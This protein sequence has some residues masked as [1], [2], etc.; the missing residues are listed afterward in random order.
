MRKWTY[1]VAALL[2]SGT[3]AT[4]TGCIDNDEPA[5]ITELRGAKAE[6]LRAKAAVQNAEAAFRTANAAYRQAEAD[7][8]A[9]KAK[10]EALKTEWQ[11]AQNQYKKDT[12][13]LRAQL[14]AETLTEMLFAQQEQ[15]KKAEQAYNEAMVDLE[16]SMIMFKN[17]KYADELAKV[18]N[19]YT[20]PAASGTGP[21]T[22]V[23]GLKDIASSMA[24]AQNELA[25]LSR[26]KLIIQS[27]FNADDL[28]NA[29][30][31]Q[32][33]TQQGEIKG[34]QENLAKLKDIQG[35]P[36][37][38]WDAK[39]QELKKESEDITT[40]K[41]ALATAKASDP[42]YMKAKQAVEKADQ[43]LKVESAFTFDVPAS[44][45]DGFHSALATVVTAGGSSTGLASLTAI[46]NLAVQ[47][48]DFKYSYPNGIRLSARVGADSNDAGVQHYG[49]AD[50]LVG[51]LGAIEDKVLTDNELIAAKAELTAAQ[52]NVNVAYAAYK[53]D[54]TAWE[55]A[56]KDFNAAIQAGNYDAKKNARTDI[57]TE[58]ADA[59]KA[60]TDINA[61]TEL[62]ADAK[63]AAVKAAKE[64]FADKYIAY[65]TD[66]NKLDGT[67]TVDS[68][69]TA[70][71]T[72]E[73]IYDAVVA[74][75]N[76]DN[77]FGVAA[78]DITTADAKTLAGIYNAAIAKIGFGDADQQVAITYA[79][80]KKL[81]SSAQSGFASGSAKTYFGEQDAYLTA[82][83]AVDNAADWNK[84]NDAL[85]ALQ[86]AN[87]AEI[88]AIS[89]A[90][91]EANNVMIAADEKYAAQ[92]AELTAKAAGISN[93][94][95]IMENAIKAEAGSGTSITNYDT[96]LAAINKAIADIEGSGSITPGASTTTGG[97]NH[98]D[99]T[100]TI[101][102]LA[103][104]QNLL[105]TYQTLLDA[106]KAGNY[107]GEYEA[108]IKVLDSEIANKQL[109]IDAL[110]KQFETLSAKKDKLVELMASTTPAE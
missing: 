91:A 77:A 37:A 98:P 97:I 19:G 36:L 103:E 92:E 21:G 81:D 22:S 67:V 50:A 13:A 23:Q 107:S 71:N 43:D 59:K 57:M 4:F 33:A 89:K 41:G 6:L 11:A 86:K 60:I 62:D 63:A 51:L 84:L 3:T 14:D 8:Q 5:G 94:M 82:K 109:E 34:I 42:D 49:K 24:T 68:K 110:N 18:I 53:A 108:T 52:K 9:E 15:T 44:I 70:S 75:T 96:A 64:A 17:S 47:G 30:N 31:N 12:L 25:G 93:L 27:K 29:L 55:K 45:Q 76:E 32:I 58:F 102:T 1:L 95:T 28:A 106:V 7:V 74:E 73:K 80:W 46:N 26:N 79:D 78:I 66:R 101:G 90:K 87:D 56:M 88:L 38:D 39:Y 105:K 69:V 85:L 61:D 99:A 54:S 65:A 100:I 48:A 83:D 16:I 35:T 20:I 10:Q 40:Q 104:A 2:L 72:K